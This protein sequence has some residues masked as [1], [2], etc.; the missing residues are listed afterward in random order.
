[1]RLHV[2]KYWVALILKWLLLVWKKL[3]GHSYSRPPINFRIMPDSSLIIS[4]ENGWKWSRE[5]RDVTSQTSGRYKGPFRLDSVMARLPPSKTTSALIGRSFPWR[6]AHQPLFSASLHHQ[7][8]CVAKARLAAAERLC[9]LCELRSSHR[10]LASRPGCSRATFHTRTKAASDRHRFASV[11]QLRL[12]DVGFQ[13]RD[14]SARP[15]GREGELDSSAA[16]CKPG[17]GPLGLAET[18]KTDI[19]HWHVVFAIDRPLRQP[20]RMRC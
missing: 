7:Q 14:R 15:C 1:M 17:K 18:R 10:T 20:I 13:A 4:R 11:R 6:P 5:A 8:R 9:G 19:R 12:P 3:P 2:F 16:M